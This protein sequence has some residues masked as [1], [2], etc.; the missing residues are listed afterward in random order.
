MKR[1]FKIAISWILFP[2][3]FGFSSDYRGAWIDIPTIGFAVP[4]THQESSIGTLITAY[5]ALEKTSLEALP[6]RIEILKQLHDDLSNTRQDS[7]DF[8]STKAQKLDHLVKKK[9]W[10]LEK[11]YSLYQNPNPYEE[12][13]NVGP[14]DKN[15]TPLFLVNKVLFDFKLP[16]YWGLFWLEALDPCHRFLT[17]HYLKW[18]EKGG[19][20]PFFLWLE[21][22]EIPHNSIQIDFLTENDLE[23]HQLDIVDGL[24]KHHHTGEVVEFDDITQEYIFALTLDKKL[25][26]AK[27]NE[28]IRHSSLTSGKPVLGAGALKIKAG[29]LIYIDAE[30]GHYQP[31]PRDLLQTIQII[32]TQGAVLDL[33]TV[34]VKYYLDGH[35]QHEQASDLVKKFKDSSNEPFDEKLI[36]DKR[37]FI[38]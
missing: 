29:K 32:T 4:A 1:L 18:R 20:I 13:L 27:G 38:I 30:S 37:T 31:T 19:D 17:A 10:Y 28:H 14:I 11:I 24:F 26:V 3:T 12:F 9:V 21:D 36:N 5:H 22:Q 16:I 7:T 33:E 34:Q 35:V 6:K 2:I 25:I 23:K 8:S 15:L